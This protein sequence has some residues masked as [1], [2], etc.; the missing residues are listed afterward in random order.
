MTNVLIINSSPNGN[1]SASFRLA[2]RLVAGIE[3]DDAGIDVV[4]RDVGVTPPPH[5][6]G[7]TI[8]A[9]FTPADERTEEQQRLVAFSDELVAEVKA[10][11]IVVFGSPMHNFGISS[12]LKTWFDHV[13]RAGVT[14]RYTENGPEGLLGGRKVVVVAASGGDYA[15]GTPNERLNHQVPHLMTLFS[16]LGLD[17]VTVIRAPGTA[18]GEDGIKAAETQVDALVEEIDTTGKKAA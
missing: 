7:A 2:K 5:L 10:A 1:D 4:L 13:A 14:F 6:D 15:P 9:F 18:M 11:D 17:D 12:G 3:A 8:G 16:F